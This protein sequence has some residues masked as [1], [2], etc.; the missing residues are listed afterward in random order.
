MTAGLTHHRRRP[1]RPRC[2]KR[3]E[4][5][6]YELAQPTE[7]VPEWSDFEWRIA[8][9]VAAMHGVSPLLSRALRWQGPA[10]WR[11][12]LVQQQEQTAARHV[13]I[14]ELLRLIDRQARDSGICVIAL[15]GAELHAMGLY[16][17]GERPMADV[18]LLVRAADKEAAGRM[19]ESLDFHE[20]FAVRRHSVFTKRDYAV[21]R[22]L[23]EH[24]DNGL[25][26]ELHE[27]I[28]KHCRSTARMSPN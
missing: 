11:R 27:R 9:A 8:R 4:L 5:L 16:V 23:G 15:K 7:S 17:A 12:F 25:K 14:A 26:I 3:P 2:G 20:S 10:E 21:T 1:C 13:R 6:A 22:S 28:R 19:L 24:A 18:D